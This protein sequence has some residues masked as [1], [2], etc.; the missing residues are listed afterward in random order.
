MVDINLNL[1]KEVIE[2]KNFSRKSFEGY[3]YVSC[4]FKHCNFSESN[5]RNAKF[6]FCIFIN[7]NLSLLT[8]DGCR[9]QEIEFIEC[10]ILGAKFFKCE[11]TFFSPLFRKCILH[12]CNFSDLK[13]KKISFLE[14]DMKENHFH[15]AS[16]VEASFQA[17]N[18]MGTL[19]H[20]C[21]LSKADFSTA[22]QYRI[23]LQTNKIKKAKFSLPEVLNLLEC[24]DITIE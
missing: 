10:K 21:D 22:I 15:N 5:F 18:L 2:S 7:C 6:S 24:F 19:F 9:F 1:E 23:D 8:L 12:Y 17:S 3:S 13:M 20:H 14:C 4:T 16:L 11:K